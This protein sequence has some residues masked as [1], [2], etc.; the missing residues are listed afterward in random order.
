MMGPTGTRDVEIRFHAA[1]HSGWA[2]PHCGWPPASEATKGKASSDLVFEKVVSSARVT[3]SGNSTTAMLG[4]E[5][6]S[7]PCWSMARAT[8][9]K[10]A[11]EKPCPPLPAVVVPSSVLVSVLGI[12]GVVVVVV[13][14][15]SSCTPPLARAEE[16]ALA[17]VVSRRE[18]TS[19]WT[20]LKVMLGSLGA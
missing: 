3:I 12:A 5:S 16:L 4:L 20:L 18:V 9:A 14:E 8:A 7:A 1:L 17:R 6:R 10:A 11:W 2:G 15:S 19:G 13:V